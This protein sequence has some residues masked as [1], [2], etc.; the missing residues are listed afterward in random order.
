MDRKTF[1]KYGF[2]ERAIKE[3]EKLGYNNFEEKD[4]SLFFIDILPIY[5][6]DKKS[7]NLD[8]SYTFG[9][10]K[11]FAKILE[12]YKKGNLTEDVQ[13][14]I[15][16]DGKFSLGSQVRYV[17]NEIIE[18]LVH[19]FSHKVIVKALA[20]E[21]YEIEL[22]I[23]QEVI[24]VLSTE[25][26]VS[27]LHET[28][29]ILSN[30]RCFCMFLNLFTPEEL[31]SKPFEPILNYIYTTFVFDTNFIRD[32]NKDLLETFVYA[33]PQK[34]ATEN[35]IQILREKRVDNVDFVVDVLIRRENSG[36]KDNFIKNFNIENTRENIKSFYKIGDEKVYQ[37]YCKNKKAFIDECVEKGFDYAIDKFLMDNYM[38]N[39]F[40]NRVDAMATI[41]A[42]RFALD[43]VK[44]LTL[45]LQI[46][47]DYMNNDS[48]YQKEI[49]DK[50]DIIR[51]AYLLMQK[52]KYPELTDRQKLNNIQYV[53]KNFKDKNI[54]LQE[55]LFSCLSVGK[56]KFLSDIVSKETKPDKLE[57]KNYYFEAENGENLQF[58][59][60]KFSGDDFVLTVH[61]SNFDRE[62]WP[63]E[64]YKKAWLKDKG[65]SKVLSLSLINNDKI[66]I[67]DD[68]CICFAFSNLNPRLL[69]HACSVDSFS[70]Y[71]EKKNVAISK[72]KMDLLPIEKFVRI[73]TSFNELVYAGTREKELLPSAVVCFEKPTENEIKAANDF[74]I[75][76]ILID[77]QKY[78]SCERSERKPYDYEYFYN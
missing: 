54:D 33:Y 1:K 6:S 17:D 7:G 11:N 27:I 51:T 25:E 9:Q 4:C 63:A 72:T 39:T 29:S 34:F 20:R 71:N 15:L 65:S 78:F 21:I 58:K 76:I 47:Y 23:P 66:E 14:K 30:S 48:E 52:L 67:F 13:F 37:F 64:D 18:S 36:E 44:N 42:E 8:Y 68:T 62:I 43:T 3:L 40:E 49:G 2:D 77:Q 5:N 74:N 28:G 16:Y 35:L 19:F 53:Y 12:E 50:V 56:E 46:V 75:P 41:F 32:L 73:G 24:N 26:K 31:I 10:F 22:D 59:M 57:Y 60:H 69:M 38:E 61:C 45:N 70:E 55:I